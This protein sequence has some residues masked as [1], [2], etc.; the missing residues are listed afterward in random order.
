MVLNQHNESDNNYYH[1]IT[2]IENQVK[3]N[4]TKRH[5]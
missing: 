5:K 4:K 1:I 2:S 3:L